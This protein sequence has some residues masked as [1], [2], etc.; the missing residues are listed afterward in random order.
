MEF[1]EPIPTGFTIYSKSGCHNCTKIK[2]ILNEKNIFFIDIN[3]DEYLIEERDNFLSFVENKI[4]KPY[5]TF[6]I[7][8]YDEKFI[9]GFIE[10]SEYTNKLLS[11]TELF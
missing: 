9:G 2:K 3:C 7:V 6:P 5:S 8:F 11:F 10:A 4:G 1:T